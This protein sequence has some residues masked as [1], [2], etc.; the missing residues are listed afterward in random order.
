MLCSERRSGV[1]FVAVVLTNGDSLSINSTLFEAEEGRRVGITFL[2]A[3]AGPWFNQ[4]VMSAI[5][6]FPYDR[7][8][9]VADS[10]ATLSSSDEYA[11]TLANA[12]CNSQPNS[13]LFYVNETRTRG[14]AYATLR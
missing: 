11:Q 12:I 4:Y 1:A 7:N 6:S 8:T 14:S 3:A 10:Y 5:A 2:T 9:I 13:T